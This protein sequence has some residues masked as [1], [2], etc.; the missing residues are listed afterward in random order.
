MDSPGTNRKRTGKRRID[1][2]GTRGRK[3]EDRARDLSEVGASAF[4][5]PFVAFFHTI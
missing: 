1:H 4:F 3:K 5:V 2:E